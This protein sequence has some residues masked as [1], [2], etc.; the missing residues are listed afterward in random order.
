MKFLIFV[1]S[2]IHTLSVIISPRSLLFLPALTYIMPRY[3]ALIMGESGPEKWPVIVPLSQDTIVKVKAVMCF[4]WF[5]KSM[6][7]VASN[8]FL[9]SEHDFSTLFQRELMSAR[10]K[11]PPPPQKSLF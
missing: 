1:Y 3:P 4:K 7:R 11:A 10:F 9:V 6:A 5:R 2:T 8:L